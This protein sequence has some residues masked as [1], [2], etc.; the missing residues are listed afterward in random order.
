MKRQERAKKERDAGIRERLCQRLDLPP[1]FFSGEVT[2][3]LRGRNA[4]SVRGG[5]KIL[6]YTPGE[7]RIALPKDILSILGSRLVCISYH[8]DAIGV[9]GQIDRISFEEAEA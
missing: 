6:L 8:T 4:L 7:I 9:E 5:G 2:L 3:E 1:D